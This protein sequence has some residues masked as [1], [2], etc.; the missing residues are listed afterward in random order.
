MPDLGAFGVG[1]PVRTEESGGMTAPSPLSFTDALALSGRQQQLQMWRAAQTVR[2]HV[3]QPQARQ[4]L[5]E[6]LGLTDVER[7]K[8]L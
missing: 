5:L 4:D 6:C 7:P 8:G 1:K 2:S 3:T